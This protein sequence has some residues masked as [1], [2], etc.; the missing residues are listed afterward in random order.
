MA[1]K[2]RVTCLFAFC[3][4]R[5]GAGEDAHGQST[6]DTLQATTTHAKYFRNNVN[7]EHKSV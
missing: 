7:N 3:Y 6:R 1:T 4:G 2:G 5:D